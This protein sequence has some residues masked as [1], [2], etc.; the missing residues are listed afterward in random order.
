[1]SRRKEHIPFGEDKPCFIVAEVGSNH[2]NDIKIAFSLIDS[3]RVAGADAIKF[4]IFRADLLYSKKTPHFKMYKKAPYNLI[5]DIELPREWLFKLKEYADKKGIIFFA[6]PF[7]NEAVDMLDKLDVSIFKI[8]SFEIVDLEL[9]EYIAS[10]R[11]PI[12]MSTGLAN[13]SEIDDAVNTARKAGLSNDKICLLQCASVYPA[14]P[15]I[16]NLKS[17]ETMRRAFGTVV[18]LSDHT[19]GIHISLASVAMGAKVIEKHFT[20]SRKMKGPDHPFAIEPEELKTLVSQVRDIEKAMGDGLKMGPS[21]DEI[22][23]YEKAR[24]SI[25]ARVRIPKETVITRDML[26]VKRPGYGIKP[27]F[28]NIVVGRKSK[29]DIEEDAWLN[30]DMI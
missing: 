19:L 6:S 13:L 8:A 30:W 4:Q 12:L 21:K 25:H 7:D 17:M 1:M 2:N 10:K 18:G 3:A 5:K 9:I 11:K 27:K 26:I 24:R 14:N 15:D 22:E 16:M 29:I 20:L 28:I 23:N